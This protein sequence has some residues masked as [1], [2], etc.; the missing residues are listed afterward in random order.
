MTKWLDVMPS[1]PLARGAPVLLLDFQGLARE[2]IVVGMSGHRG[3]PV[4]AF[5]DGMDEAWN[6]GKQVVRLHADRVR[7]DL[8][9]AQG[10]A[11]ALRWV[12]TRRM[13]EPGHGHALVENGRI[14]M[15]TAVD[16]LH[17]WS[18]AETTDADRRALAEAC[19]DV[20]KKGENAIVAENT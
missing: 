12:C 10:F 19:A 8:D 20:V 14:R 5:S 6:S 17:R 3:M 2:A 1:I 16:W 15:G 7:V 13:D 11:H 9:D 4:I 18:N